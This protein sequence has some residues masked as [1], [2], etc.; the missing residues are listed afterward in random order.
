MTSNTE[1]QI[2]E[3]EERL[4]QAERVLDPEL[5]AELIDDG[6][7]FVAQDGR[8]FGKAD[9]IAA[10]QPAGAVKFS[11]YETF[12]LAVRDLGDAAIVTVRVE[13]TANETDVELLFTR[14]WLKRDER[15]RIA[16][17]AVVQLSHSH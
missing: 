16:G 4:T 7:S 17:G 8:V 15:W 11:R 14:F 1:T 13:L 9:V 3:L 6:F 2:R 5:F 12:D 10:H